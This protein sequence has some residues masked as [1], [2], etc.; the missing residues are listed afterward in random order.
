MQASSDDDSTSGSDSD[1]D[2]S[3][4]SAS[5]S[6]EEEAPSKKRKAQTDV[7]PAT[8]KSKT[9]A[10][11]EGVKNLFVGNLSWNIDEDWLAREFE[12]FG[13]ITGCR[14]ITDRETGRAKG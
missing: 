13:E 4:S 11:D 6:E 8:K 2:D 7:E 1:S 10:S 14:I 3:D 9:E 5:G 12:S